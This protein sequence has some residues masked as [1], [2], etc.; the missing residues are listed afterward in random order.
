VQGRWALRDCC[1]CF[2][3]VVCRPSNLH[4]PNKLDPCPAAVQTLRFKEILAGK[5]RH[6]GAEAST[7][8]G[9]NGQLIAGGL[10]NVRILARL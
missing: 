5:L 8:Y 2:N 4:C 7:H 3:G 1:H 6:V 9:R 10:Y